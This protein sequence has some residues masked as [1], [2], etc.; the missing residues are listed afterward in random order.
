MSEYNNH[1]I[2]PVRE[3]GL[4]KMGKWYKCIKDNVFLFFQVPGVIDDQHV[5]KHFM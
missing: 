1:D 4:A 2:F 3:H 5:S